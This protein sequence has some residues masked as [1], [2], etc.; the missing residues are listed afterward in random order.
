MAAEDAGISTSEIDGI[1]IQPHH[2]PKDSMPNLKVILEGLG[3]REVT[4]TEPDGMGVTAMARAAEVLLSGRSQF[5]VVCKVMTTA[6][7]ILTPIMDPESG[8]VAGG[9]QFEVPYGLGYSMQKF[10]LVARRWMHRYGVT[11]DQ[12]GWL[13]VI[14]REHASLNPRAALKGRISLEDY[15]GSRWVVDP[16]RLLDC[17][18]PVNGAFG[19]LMCRA[20]TARFL[21]KTP[22][23]FMGWAASPRGFHEMLALPEELDEGP[24]YWAQS[25]FREC[26]IGPEE[27]DVWMLH[28]GFS[29]FP[30]LWM[31]S[32]GLTPRGCAAAYVEGGHRIRFDGEHPT[33]T[34]GG[35]L[36]EGRMHGAGQI[37]EAVQQLRGEAGSRQ[38][39]RAETAIVTTAWPDVGS[40]AILMKGEL[41]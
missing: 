30:L 26:A 9:A 38:A 19:Y 4:W 6:A 8:S 25:L 29:T 17:D 23:H 33:N 3:I 1:N 12:I 7:S 36:S 13:P 40:A 5:V 10:A 35:N 24:N 32:L 20:E 37:L 2:F 15:L 18:Y 28:D 39:H 22:V 14:Q 27:M 41:K 31:E 16:L 11:H 34:N 21:R